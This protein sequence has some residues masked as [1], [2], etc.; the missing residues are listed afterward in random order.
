VPPYRQGKSRAIPPTAV[1][2][3]A[4]A[5]ELTEHLGIPL[6]VALDLAGALR[7]TGEHS[8]AEGL[9]I[10]LDVAAM[11]RRVALRLNEAVE[12]NPPPRRGRPPR[13]KR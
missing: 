6:L 11:E 13:S 5:M 12:A 4:V 1:L 8:P 3:V 2:T 10:R 9:F 7:H